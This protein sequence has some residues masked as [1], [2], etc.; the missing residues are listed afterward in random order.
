[1]HF[2]FFWRGGRKKNYWGENKAR[3]QQE[4]DRRGVTLKPRPLFTASCQSCSLTAI[5]GVD[6]FS[7]IFLYT[8]CSRHDRWHLKL[9]FQPHGQYLILEIQLKSMNSLGKP[10]S[11]LVPALFFVWVIWVSSIWVALIAP[12]Y[13]LMLSCAW[14]HPSFL[15]ASRHKTKI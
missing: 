10:Q 4:G 11:L 5:G 6:P 14:E 13:M 8:L 2:S 15:K 12:Y 9:I 1:M 7:I 3:R